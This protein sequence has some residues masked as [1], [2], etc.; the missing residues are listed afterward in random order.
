MSGQLL[1]R[2]VGLR[3][4]TASQNAVF[5]LAVSTTDSHGGIISPWGS[6]PTYTNPVLKNSNRAGEEAALFSVAYD[7]AGHGVAGLSASVILAAGWDA[8]DPATGEPL[9]TQSELDLTLDYQVPKG[10]LHGLWLRLQ[11]NQL[12]D[13]STSLSGEATTEWRAIV[14]WEIPLI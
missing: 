4:T 10:V 3:V 5:N 11:R 7:F 13:S 6:N 14:Y 12:H 1:S 2:N 9:S 8:R